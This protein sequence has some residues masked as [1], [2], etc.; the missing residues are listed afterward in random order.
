MKQVF[1]RIF[2][3]TLVLAVLIAGAG[4]ALL[5][6]SVKA[7]GGACCFSFC[8]PIYSACAGTYPNKYYQTSWDCIVDHGGENC[9]ACNP[10]C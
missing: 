6:G 9:E 2:R 5:N 7:Q 10:T 4:F 3:K 8:N 1:S